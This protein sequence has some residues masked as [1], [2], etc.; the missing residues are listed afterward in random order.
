MKTGNRFIL[1]RKLVV[2]TFKSFTRMLEVENS[3]VSVLK[4][5][6]INFCQTIIIALLIKM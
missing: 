2:E 6:N 3:D 1:V 4:T 5:T